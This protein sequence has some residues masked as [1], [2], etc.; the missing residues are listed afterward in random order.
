MLEFLLQNDVNLKKIRDLEENQENRPS[1]QCIL[2][3]NMRIDI[4]S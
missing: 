2:I 4:I 3:E 1:F